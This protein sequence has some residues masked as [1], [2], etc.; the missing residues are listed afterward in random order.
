MLSPFELESAGARRTFRT[1]E[2]T[3]FDRG[4]TLDDLPIT[5]PIDTVKAVKDKIFC[6]V[7]CIAVSVHPSC[8][9]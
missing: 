1:A 2:L 8:F 6:K 9:D 3:E 7:C 5:N 4:L